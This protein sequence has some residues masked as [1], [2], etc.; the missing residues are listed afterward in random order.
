LDVI[1]PA[2]RLL[3]PASL[4]F[5]QARRSWTGRTTGEY[6]PADVDYIL[7]L[8]VQL[9]YQAG[10]DPLIPLCQLSLETGWLTSYWSARPRR[11][12]AGIGVTGA[13]GA[14]VSFPSWQ[15]A[16]RAHVGRLLAYALPALDPQGAQTKMQQ[17]L[18]LEAL[19]WRPLAGS[20]R[21]TGATL[22]GLARSW[23]E[24]PEYAWKLAKIGN[25]YLEL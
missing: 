11:N 4:G 22:E 9:G 23:A 13:P 18:I 25:S 19:S 24:D 15:H 8:Y 1:S 21:G 6:T 2:T 20:K 12:P 10:L 16:A 17:D 5:N 7:G 14:G 3:G